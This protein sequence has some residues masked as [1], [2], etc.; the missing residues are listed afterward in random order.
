MSKPLEQIRNSE[1]VVP[2][3]CTYLSKD[4]SIGPSRFQ[5]PVDNVDVLTA[6]KFQQVILSKFEPL[7]NRG[8]YL[9]GKSSYHRPSVP[10]TVG[11]DKHVTHI[12][13]T[14]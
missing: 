12:L 1:D 5:A 2:H 3:Q 8:I 6:L 11:E 14:V 7:N 10:V 9:V 13:C 4:S